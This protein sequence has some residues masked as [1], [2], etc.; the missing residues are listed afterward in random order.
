MA[1][2]P[3]KAKGNKATEGKIGRDRRF[4]GMTPE[5]STSATSILAEWPFPVSAALGSAVRAKGIEREIKARLPFPDR[6]RLTIEDGRIVLAMPAGEDDRLAHASRIVAD[7]LERA[8]DLP[9]L[10]SEVEDILTIT[11]RERLKWTKDGRLQSAGT[12]TVKLRGRGKAVT[13]HVFD[14]RGIEDLLDRDLPTLWREED[15]RAAAEARRRAAGKAALTRAGKGGDRGAASQ[16]R[17]GPAEA[18]DLDGWDAFAKA[19][20]LR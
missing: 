9:V 6:K 11:P 18:L 13:F 8:E 10:P 19:G 14:P 3:A 17:S 15:A 20:L 2:L 1:G 7:V 5:Q 4:E 12:R 16:K